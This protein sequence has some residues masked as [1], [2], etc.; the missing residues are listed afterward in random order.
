MHKHIYELTVEDR[1]RQPATMRFGS[2][3]DVGATGYPLATF[4]LVRAFF[5]IAH[6]RVVACRHN[7][8]LV[9]PWERCHGAIQATQWGEAHK[10][11]LV[12]LR[13]RHCSA[14]A[15]DAVY[16]GHRVVNRIGQKGITTV[17]V[18][19]PEPTDMRTAFE[20]SIALCQ[21]LVAV[22]A[23]G[24]NLWLAIEQLLRQQLADIDQELADDSAWLEAERV[25]MH[26]IVGERSS[27]QPTIN[28]RPLIARA[29]EH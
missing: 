5:A 11:A 20:Q 12:I 9:P 23:D 24:R 4:P 13:H 28:L 2:R 27:A 6:C 29:Q 18:V 21:A 19:G 3:E 26:Q 15:V 1:H 14:P 22:E 10:G 16:L 25:V 7:A 8:R 17:L